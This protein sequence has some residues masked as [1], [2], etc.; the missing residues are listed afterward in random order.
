MINDLLFE[1]AKLNEVN[2]IAIGGS[3]ATELFDEKSDYDIYIYCSRK[4][5]PLIRKEILSKYC[6]YMEIDNC[7]WENE[8]NC[9]L[10]NNI[11]IDIIYRNISDFKKEIESVAKDFQAH[12][13]YTTCMWHN[14]LTSKIFYDQDNQLTN[15]K[16]EYSIPYPIELKNNIIERNI[17]LLYKY[18]PSYNKQILKAV[19]R[20]DLVSMCHRTA[21]FMES[22]FDIIF[23]I[24]EM[25]HP[26]EKRLI[27]I[28]LDKCKILPLN[29]EK[30][31]KK[32]YLDLYSNPQY[33]EEDLLLIINELKK[34]I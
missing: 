6:L 9:V 32:L 19:K 21:A 28:C 4:I 10:N 16:E 22:Y 14:L 8:D 7:F 26:G 17:K 18:L 13:G 24:N 25:T 12:N 34:I 2:A 30:N 11:D 15:L 33:I 23:A 1:F 27:S 5:D 3:R 20:N 31:I 29:F